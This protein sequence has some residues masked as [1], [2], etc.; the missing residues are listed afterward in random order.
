MP[1]KLTLNQ[2]TSLTHVGDYFKNNKT[3]EIRARDLGG[4]NIQLYVRKDSFKQFFT[5][6]LRLE[7][8]V[9]QDYQAAKN[10]ILNI[11][12]ELDPNGKQIISLQNISRPLN[13]QSLH[14]EAPALSKA[15]KDFEGQSQKSSNTS[16]VTNSDSKNQYKQRTDAR[17]IIGENFRA[18]DTDK[19]MEALI[20]G[21]DGQKEISTIIN[22]VENKEDRET[23]QQNFKALTKVLFGSGTKER[24]TLDDFLKARDFSRAWLKELPGAIIKL[25]SSATSPTGSPSNH[26]SDLINRLTDFSKRIEK[27]NAPGTIDYEGGKV[28]DSYADL[29]IVDPTSKSPTLGTLSAGQKEPTF[30]ENIK[31]DYGV[32]TL[33]SYSNVNIVGGSA[34]GLKINYPPLELIGPIGPSELDT[35]YQE[36]GK[37]IDEKIESTITESS[38]GYSTA[39]QFFIVH[40]P[41]LNPFDKATLTPKEKDLVIPAFIKA[42]NKWREK[43]PNLRIKVELPKGIDERGILLEAFRISERGQ[44]RA[45]NAK[46]NRELTSGNL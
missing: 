19:A 5:D 31:S 35:L 45:Q 14:F 22:A 17:A 15:I 16:A 12:K 23:L 26:E 34:D 28:G 24:P 40:L 27:W 8:F 2:N 46:M 29:V 7:Y 20:S 32:T 42:T 37:K 41:L 6:K 21:A 39:D 13:R 1:T 25:N 44:I 38:K 11:V 33:S 4:G 3:R 30:I 43:H 36:I 18:V 9:K 10:Q